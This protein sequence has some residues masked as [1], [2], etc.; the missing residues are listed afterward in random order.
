M[1]ITTTHGLPVAWPRRPAL[2]TAVGIVALLVSYSLLELPDA[3]VATLVEEDGVVEW[4]G[5]L[6]LFAAAGLFLAS[7]VVARRRRPAEINRVGVW[8]LLL[9]A[10]GFLVLAGEEIS[11]GQRLFGFGTPEALSSVNAQHETTVHNLAVFQGTLLDSDRLFQLGALV[12]VVLIPVAAWLVPGAR[13]RITKV[14]PVVPLWIAALFVASE[15]LS[16]VMRHVVHGVYRIPFHGPSAYEIEESSIEVMM[17][18][19]GL[20]TLLGL[21]K[22]RAGEPR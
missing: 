1:S 5:A 13:R 8:L 18:L 16:F 22:R 4:I 6:G 19:A 11:W 2:A 10:A 17:A 21:L 9:L 14:L 15:L 20:L 7:F 12:F 3:T